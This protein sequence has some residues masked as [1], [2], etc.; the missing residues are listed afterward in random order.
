MRLVVLL[1]FWDNFIDVDNDISGRREI[2]GWLFVNSLAVKLIVIKNVSE[3]VIRFLSLNKLGLLKFRKR[4]LFLSFLLFLCVRLVR[5][6]KSIRENILQV[7]IILVIF[8][9]KNNGNVGKFRSF[10]FE[11]RNL[12]ESLAFLDSRLRQSH[13][14]S[15]N[16]LNS[17]SG[18]RLIG[19]CE[20]RLRDFWQCLRL[21]GLGF[22]FDENFM[23]RN[24]RNFFR[25]RRR[26]QQ[27]LKL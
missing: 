7:F 24:D 3:L 2:R 14:F 19:F 13:G 15:L 21:G 5:L 8:V 4:L 16:S 20:D 17:F 11:N 18:F 27:F 12:R 6:I 1:N 25:Q 22:F 10:F 9:R 23:F 26:C